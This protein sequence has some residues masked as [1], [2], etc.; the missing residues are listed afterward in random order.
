MKLIMMYILPC[1]GFPVLSEVAFSWQAIR[2]F[3]DNSPRVICHDNHATNIAIYMLVA[4]SDGK[5]PIALD[6]KNLT[7]ILHSIITP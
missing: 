1:L 2:E 6:Q 4:V 5:K 3:N 7:D